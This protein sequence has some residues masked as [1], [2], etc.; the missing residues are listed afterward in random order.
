LIRNR[1]FALLLLLASCGAMPPAGGPARSPAS[2]ASPSDL[3]PSDLDFLIR[4]DAARLREHPL[5]MALAKGGAVQLHDTMITTEGGGLFRLILPEIEKAN[6]VVVGGRITAEGYKGDGV[7][8]V[9]QSPGDSPRRTFATDAALS[10]L[11]SSSRHIELYERSAAPRDE[12]ALYVVLEDKGLLL[13]TPAET[14]SILR[15]LRDGPDAARL[16]PPPRGLLSFAGRFRQGSKPPLPSSAASLRQLGVGLTR[17]S[18]S[19]EADD[20]LRVEAELVYDSDKRAE[21]A[22]ELARQVLDR[23]ALLGPAYGSLSDSAKLAAVG[24]VLGLRLA[25]PFALLAGLH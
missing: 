3:L 9:E 5:M 14:D 4:I 10:R 1:R 22:A 11:P 20:V 2:A 17:Y 19:V 7:V 16:E 13:A 6:L 23:V 15:V 25:V 12:A 21:T 24:P 8:A 18:G